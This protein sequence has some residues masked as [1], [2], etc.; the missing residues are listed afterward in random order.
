MCQR[1]R[2]EQARSVAVTFEPHPVAVLAPG[3]APRL[4][5][6]LPLK[7]ELLERS[8]IEHLLILPFTE[9]FSRWPA[10]HFVDRVL[11]GSLHVSGVV[12]GENFRFGHR[13][14]GNSQLLQELGKRFQFFTEVLPSL[15][16]RGWTV[17]SSQIRCLLDE[18]R[19]RI[20]N[21]LL[22]LCLLR[23]RPDRARLGRGTEPSGAHV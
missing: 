7:L 16:V 9:E 2:A 4:L 13:Q 10:E 3:K 15:L 12:V 20:A 14:S 1:A 18:G 8:G 5:T 6:P 23:S 11:R 21:R 19:V 17:S 22:G